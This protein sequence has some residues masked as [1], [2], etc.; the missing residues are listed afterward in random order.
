MTAGGGLSDFA[1][2]AA[3]WGTYDCGI[4]AGADITGDSNVDIDDLA[5]HTERWLDGLSCTSGTVHVDSVTAGTDAGT[6]GR[7][8]LA[9][10]VIVHDN[11]GN[12]VEGVTVTGTFTDV[13]IEQ[14]SF[15]TDVEGV[16]FLVTNGQ[17]SNPSFNFC[18]D[19]L[20]HPAMIYASEDN[21]ETCDNY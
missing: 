21:I 4:C 6:A 7:K 16:A 15:V 17:L 18:V 9:A 2:F 10:T 14:T 5:I 19:D 3:Q 8:K 13:F 11:C 1:G 20:A 12:P